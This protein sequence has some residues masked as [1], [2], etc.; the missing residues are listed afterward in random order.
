MFTCSG[1]VGYD[2]RPN[3]VKNFLAHTLQRP[4]IEHINL[5]QPARVDPN[6]PIE[7]TMGAIS[8]MVEAGYV[9]HLG[10]SEAGQDTIR[11]AHA[12]PPIS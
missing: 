2:T 10:R 1:F 7:E 6:V 3:A 5:Y 12:V 11:R 8:E 4:G 9:R